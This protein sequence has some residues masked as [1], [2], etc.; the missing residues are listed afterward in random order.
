MTSEAMD[1]RGMDHLTR[2]RTQGAGIVKG[3]EDKRDH[4]RIPDTFTQNK[5]NISAGPLN[6]K[7]LN[8]D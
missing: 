8:P 5:N 6:P 7:Q 1:I 4:G 3:W 2:W